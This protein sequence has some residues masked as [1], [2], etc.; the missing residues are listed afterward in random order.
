MAGNW[1]FRAQPTGR[2]AME[3][4]EAEDIVEREDEVLEDLP[5]MSAAEIDR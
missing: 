3:A 2:R 5:G 1:L 4:A